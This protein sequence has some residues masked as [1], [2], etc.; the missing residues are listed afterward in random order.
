[1]LWFR[2]SEFDFHCYPGDESL[3]ASGRTSLDIQ[4]ILLMCSR[5]I[6]TLHRGKS[7]PSEWK[8]VVLRGVDLVPS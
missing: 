5:E 4:P 3:I 7:E 2:K 6:S 8:Y 1:M